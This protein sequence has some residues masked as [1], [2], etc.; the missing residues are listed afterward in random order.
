MRKDPDCICEECTLQPAEF[1][2]VKWSNPPLK[3]LPILFIGEAPGEVETI[4]GIPFT[5]GAGKMHYGLCKQAGINKQMCPHSNIIACR[6]PENRTPTDLEVRCCQ[7]RIIREIQLQKPRLII[8][9]GDTAMYAL[10]GQKRIMTQRGRFL[11][12]LDKFGYDCKVL[13]C[14]HPSFVMRSRQ[15]IPTAVATYKTIHDYLMGKKGGEFDPTILRDPSAEEL[16]SFLDVPKGT[17]VAVDTETTGLNTLQDNIIGYSFCKGGQEAAAVLFRGGQADPRWEVCKEFLEDPD[18]GKCWQ[19]GSFDTEIAR[20]WGILDQGF[21]YDTRLAEQMIHSDLP[22][23]LDF[24][25]AQYTRIPPYKPPKRE[26]KNLMQWGVEKVLDYAAMDAITTYTVMEEQIGHLSEKQLQLMHNLLIPLVRAIGRIER[27]G[28]KVNEESIGALYIKL[29]PIVEE[30]EK[31][32]WVQSVNPRSPVQ[33][34]EWLGL[35]TT[36]EEELLSQIKRG[37]PKLEWMEKLLRFRK[38]D[39]LLSKY[40]VGIYERMREGRIHTHFKI[41]GTG[42]GRLSSENPNLQNVPDEMR[43]VY[44]PD[45]GFTLISADYSQIELWVGAILAGGKQMFKDLQDG[46]D[47]HYIAC[48]LC[49][50]NIPI[51]YG[52]RKKDFTHL[53]SNAAKAIVFG[54]F[55]GRS[56]YSIA[57]EFGVTV[58][59]AQRW[60]MRVLNKYPELHDYQE[61]CKEAFNKRGFLETPFGR[62]RYLQTITQGFNFPVQST[63]SDITLGSIVLMDAEGI[64]ILASVHDSIVFQVSTDNWLQHAKRVREIMER[65]I[66]ELDG[67][68]FRVTYEKGGNWYEMEDV[69]NDIK[70]GGPSKG[71]PSQGGMAT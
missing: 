20:T 50:P 53:Q 39:V 38:Y 1:K 11:Q 22:S 24:L 16:R 71:N 17:V 47:V 35:K 67:V 64:Q 29:G 57:R 46:V 45:I 51:V 12:L 42:T 8:A 36:G 33:L 65:P 21:A 32:F 5:G 41:E 59:E 4:T 26:M 2:H 60:Q 63:A 40:I 62:V 37:H 54:T 10:T 23:D 34:R 25:R 43:V 70:R 68:Q 19:N 69:T 6:P 61:K 66:L 31:E 15:W 58:A 55:Y 48:Q 14:M 9:L 18:R 28:F 27:R 52:T 49:F 13:C 3:Q 56:P 7:P 30:V 44:E